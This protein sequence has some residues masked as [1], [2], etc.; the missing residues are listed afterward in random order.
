M[1]VAV[2]GSI[3]NDYLMRFPG[4]I[5][6]QLVSDQ[7]DRVSLSFLVDALEVRRG[8]VAANICFGMGRLGLDPQLVGSVGR[9]F[10]NEYEPH[11][12]AS[13]VDT[14]TVRVSSKYRTAM[15]LCTSDQDENQIASFCPGAMEESAEIDLTDLPGS[16][17]DPELVIV[18]PNEPGAMLRHTR[19]VLEQG[20]TLAADPSQ[21]LPRLEDEQVREIIDGA[22]YLLSNEYEA[23]LI[24][25]KTGWSSQQV[26]D[27]VGLRI[28]TYGDKGSIIEQSGEPPL[29]VPAVPTADDVE[30]E[31]TG[32]G[33]A[34]RA[35]FFAGCAHGLALERAAQLASAVA[36]C[37]LETVGPQEYKLDAQ[38]LL[39]RIDRTYGEDA[40]ADLEP[41]LTSFP[42]AH[43]T[44]HPEQGEEQPF[45]GQDR[46]HAADGPD[47]LV[48]V[49]PTEDERGPLSATTDGR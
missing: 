26:L 46:G 14:S 17:P 47:A 22:A 40:A 24:D 28:T 34:F 10:F 21:Q 41:I 13:G 44:T 2:S 6:D 33:D 16:A 12:A 15:F 8:G 45:D 43:R 18:C 19:Q 23:A 49:L 35:G 25:S 32:I 48:R 39:P 29:E 37:A 31:P 9:D 5:R 30:L 7:L 11:L 4:S 20:W 42:P 1:R 38:Q 3:A 36:T 27:H